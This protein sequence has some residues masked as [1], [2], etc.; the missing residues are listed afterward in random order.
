MQT[1][2]SKAQLRIKTT[3]NEQQQ[4]SNAP[5]LG[6]SCPSKVLPSAL[7]LITLPL[8]LF[9]S[10]C[11]VLAVAF[12]EVA[13]EVPV[14][15]LVLENGLMDSVGA[16]TAGAEEPPCCLASDAAAPFEGKK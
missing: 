2:S 12:P 5:G 9:T 15:G 13:A 14:A 10:L 16:L 6:M 11:T 8:P 7:A 4:H 3:L 1:G